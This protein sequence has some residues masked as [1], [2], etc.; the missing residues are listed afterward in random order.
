MEFKKGQMIV[1]PHCSSD[2]VVQ[3]KAEMDG[4]KKLGDCL[5][6]NICGVKLADL[7]SSAGKK[8]KDNSKD[9]GKT[10]FADFL[11]TSSPEK[12]SDY[13]GDVS[14]RR[15]CRD[16]SHFAENPFY[17]RCMLHEHDVG[18]MDDCPDFS[19]KST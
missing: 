11:G 19:A 13:L 12:D 10:I 17:T 1:C 9:Q 5:A 6:C 8:D 14:D 3:I 16:C 4:W 15:F 2:A 18:P 7:T